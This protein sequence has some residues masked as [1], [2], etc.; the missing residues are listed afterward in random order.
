M[1]K[2]VDHVQM[3]M[4]TGGEAKATAFYEGILGVPRIAKPLHL[5]SRG[6]CWFESETVKI[7]LGVEQ[8]FRP[9]RKAHP[10]LLVEDLARLTAELE[11]AG[12]PVNSD[13]PLEG[14]ERVYVDDPFGNRLELLEPTP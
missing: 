10:G 14:Y 7:H 9:A 4:P 2:A 1:I 11:R 5:A 13:L 6:G 3:A 8:D 12:H